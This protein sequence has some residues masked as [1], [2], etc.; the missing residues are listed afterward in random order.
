MYEPIFEERPT[1][2]QMIAGAAFNADDAIVK[3][4][5]SSQRTKQSQTTMFDDLRSLLEKPDFHFLY[6]SC[7]CYAPLKSARETVY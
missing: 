6:V 5:P 7:P 4:L 3:A 2:I 1:S